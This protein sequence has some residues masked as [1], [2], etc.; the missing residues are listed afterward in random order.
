MLINLAFLGA[1]ASV[2]IIMLVFFIIGLLISIIAK[3]KSIVI[4]LGVLTIICEICS[5][6]ETP[7]FL[8][9]NGVAVIQMWA[10]IVEIA[11][12]PVFIGSLMSFIYF[13]HRSR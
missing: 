3:K 6:I 1:D 5:L 11:V 9:G 7:K 8:A 4:I 12:L 10:V 2:Y 13:R